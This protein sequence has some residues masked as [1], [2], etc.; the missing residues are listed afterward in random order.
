MSAPK[1]VQ[2]LAG[3]LSAAGRTPQIGLVLD[4]LVEALLVEL[5]LAVEL[6]NHHSLR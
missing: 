2:M 1:V 5:V 6:G 4:P 3:E